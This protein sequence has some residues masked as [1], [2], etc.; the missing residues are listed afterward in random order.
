MVL[1]R[2]HKCVHC[3]APPHNNDHADHIIP[4][5]QPNWWDGDWSIENGQ[6]LCHLCHTI[7]TAKERA[8]VA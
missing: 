3:G 8:H 2:Y 7:K 6:R 1:A 4:L 5:P